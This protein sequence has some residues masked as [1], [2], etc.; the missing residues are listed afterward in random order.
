M[1]LSEEMV[2]TDNIPLGRPGLAR[3]IAT[4][5]AFLASSESSYITGEE[6]TV[7]GGFTQ[8]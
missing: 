8:G 7:D 3:E 2:P 5:V 1:G 4:A 6:I